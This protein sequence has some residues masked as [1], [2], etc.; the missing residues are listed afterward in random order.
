MS[1]ECLEKVNAL[2]WRFDCSHDSMPYWVAQCKSEYPLSALV[3][4][5]KALCAPLPPTQAVINSGLVP[6]IIGLLRSNEY[7]FEMFFTGYIRSSNCNCS[8]PMDVVSLIESKC[9]LYTVDDR[10]QVE[11]RWILGGIAAGFPLCICTSFKLNA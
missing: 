10:V 4:L 5:R 6:L 3:K 11:C 9:Q 1:K 2:L 7:N 8:I